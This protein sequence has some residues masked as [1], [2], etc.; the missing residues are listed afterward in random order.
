MDAAVHGQTPAAPGARNLWRDRYVLA[1][2]AAA[3]ASWLVIALRLLPAAIA[4]RFQNDISFVLIAGLVVVAAGRGFLR[5]ADRPARWAYGALTAAFLAW[6]AA[7]VLEMSLART[8]SA[9]HRGLATDCLYLLSYSLALL[10]AE[11]VA[12]RR[13]APDVSLDL[14][15]EL[16]A[17]V[18][19][20]DALLAYFLLIP[21]NLDPA[22]VLRT[23]T[24]WSYYALFDAIFFA[25]VMQLRRGMRG[26]PGRPALGWLA[27]MGAL[28]LSAD[29]LE[30]VNHAAN[31]TQRSHH[32]AFLLYFLAFTAAAGA[33]RSGAL[34]APARGATIRS[35]ARQRLALP[36]FSP[37][38]VFI[39]AMPLVHLLHELLVPAP[40][41]LAAARS[42]V[43]ILT[44]AVLGALAGL[45]WRRFRRLHAE[46]LD[47]WERTGEALAR[48]RLFESIGRLAAGVAHDFNNRLTVILG[49]A[50]RLA[51]RRPTDGELAAASAAISEAAA[52]A[53]RLTAELLAVGR[54]Q[55]AD[56]RTIDLA[57]LA[58]ELGDEARRLVPEA[59]RVDVRFEEGALRV[60]IDRLHLLRIVWNLISNA[61]DAM[62]AG[63]EISLEIGARHLS[64]S[65][66]AAGEALPEGDYVAL[67]VTD[68]G[69]G[70]SEEQRA[71]IFDPFFTTKEFGRGSGLGLAAMLGLV[72]LNAGFV[73]VESAPARGSRFEVLFPRC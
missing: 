25:R 21:Y 33:A 69:I 61:A 37:V 17:T 43:V 39:V 2:L 66:D 6:I 48:S 14:Q 70:M 15:V 8:W 22:S 20:V 42:V 23:A 45:A 55:K 50:S 67:A 51:G 24:Y 32:L 19:V 52:Q 5:A 9:A 10:A 44:T 13:E 18:I 7:E 64:A 12:S 62:P 27:A 1:T 29:T 41:A 58:P 60:E 73:L 4:N 46:I 47:A 35:A 11:V 40:A 56:R 36:R 72:R 59:V 54:M 31:G 3:I 57:A 68:R 49:H 30:T 71:R 65:I 26:D 38:L 16:L 53:S 34:D 63:G 28:L